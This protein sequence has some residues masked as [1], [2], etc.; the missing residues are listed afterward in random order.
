MINLKL[1]NIWAFYVWLQMIR[2]NTV[3]EI[4]YHKIN[5]IKNWIRNQGVVGNLI[6]TGVSG[7]LCL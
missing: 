2:I 7:Y 1:D 4:K 5:T 3:S 6:S